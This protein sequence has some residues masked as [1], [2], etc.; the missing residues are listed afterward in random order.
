MRVVVNDANILI[1][2]IDANLLELFFKLEFTMNIADSVVGEFENE[3]DVA[4]IDKFIKTRK[5]RLHSFSYDE[6]TEIIEMFHPHRCSG[7]KPRAT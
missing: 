5:L 1:D 6:I 4:R 2:L 3:D 7:Y